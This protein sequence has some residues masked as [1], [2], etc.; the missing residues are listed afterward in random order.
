MTMARTC[1]GSEHA[2]SGLVLE[3]AGARLSSDAAE[4]RAWH[5]VSSD[6]EGP[7]R[8]RFR[9]GER[10]RNVVSLVH[11]VVLRQA[12]SDRG[13]RVPQF[14]LPEGPG[15]R[16]ACLEPVWLPAPRWWFEAGNGEAIPVF[17]CTEAGVEASPAACLA[18]GRE[19]SPMADKLVRAAGLQAGGRS[20]WSGE[21][22]ADVRAVK[23]M[24]SSRVAALWTPAEIGFSAWLRK[25]MAELA[26]CYPVTV[27]AASWALVRKAAGLGGA[28][29]AG[30]VRAGLAG[31]YWAAVGRLSEAC[32]LRVVREPG[33]RVL[34]EPVTRTLIPVEVPGSGERTAAGALFEAAL[35]S[36]R[37]PW[38][39]MARRHDVV[40]LLRE[41]GL[42]GVLARPVDFSGPAW[43][44]RA[45]VVGA[46][47][48][49]RLSELCGVR[50]ESARDV[51]VDVGLRALAER[52]GWASVVTEAG[53]L[54]TWL[55]DGVAGRRGVSVAAA[56][57]AGA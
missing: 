47:A 26:G 52:E 27:E 7:C 50:Y 32:G 56:G 54:A 23:R 46:F 28:R 19:A 4:G 12:M 33:G 45:R 29:S 22:A 5:Q 6:D 57:D 20:G 9:D 35:V 15:R 53:N 49:K 8:F 34:W 11:E 36:G 39:E 18:G 25:F 43:S 3:A 31:C 21:V 2:T 1:S 37:P 24:R 42:G 38:A 10:K 55:V 40:G 14:V 44:A 16:A 30:G 41:L 17:H 51:E 48:A 13:W